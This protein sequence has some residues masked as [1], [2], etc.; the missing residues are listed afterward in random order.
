MPKL[1]LSTL[2]KVQKLPIVFR[3]YSI[4]ELEQ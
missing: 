4:I 1:Q 2:P 3:N